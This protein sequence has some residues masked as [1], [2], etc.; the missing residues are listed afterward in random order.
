MNNNTVIKLK[1]NVKSISINSLL[2]DELLNSLSKNQIYLILKINKFI[3]NDF[4]IAHDNIPVNTKEL[5]ELIN[6]NYDVFRKELSSLRKMGVLAK[7]KL[8]IKKY[9]KSKNVIVCNPWIFSKN[10]ICYLEIL[11]IF[12]NTKWRYIADGKSDRN[13]FEYVMWEYNVKNRDKCNCIIC[14]ETN[15][16]EVHHISP[17]STD[18]DNRTNI[19]NGITLCRKHHN[20]KI[21]GSFHNTY[22][23]VN[24]TKEQLQEYINI[25]REE[26][27][28]PKILI[29]EIINK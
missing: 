16:L 19:N 29:D 25:K 24:N 22:G 11:N 2:L 12:K 8:S 6:E 17:Y 3:N 27:D 13:S 4:V 26:I 7:T 18:Y 28:L 5:S 14:G 23:T 1:N 9:D 10:N 20:S 15:E 21:K